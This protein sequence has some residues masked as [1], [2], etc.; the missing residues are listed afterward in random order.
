MIKTRNPNYRWYMLALTMATYGL[1][2]G[3]ARMSMLVL[4]KQI[5]D[6]LDLSMVAIGTIWGMDPLAGVFIGLPSGLLADRFGV[7]RTVVVVCILAGVFGALRG[8]TVDFI[9]MAGSMFLFGLTVASLPSIAPKVTMVW[10]GGRRL[11]LANAMLNVA[12]SV[13]AMT[14]TMFSATVFSPWLGGWRGVM[15]LYGA[16]AVLMGFLWLF[17]GREPDRGEVPEATEV[18]VPFRQ[19]LSKVVRIRNVW[20]FGVITMTS[21]GANTGFAGYLPLYLRN[22]GWAPAAADGAMT[23]MSG[24]SILG[25]IP[26]VMLAER[27][28]RKGILAMSIIVQALGIGLVSVLDTPGVWLLI[29][30]GGFLRSGA[31]ALYNV[32]IFETEGVGSTYGGTAVGLSSTIAM[33]GAFLAPPLGNSFAGI[34]QGLPMVFWGGMAML[35]LP[36]LFLVKNRPVLDNAP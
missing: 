11:G 10:F 20:L 35:G 30:V 8:F 23:V 36:A 27:T 4:F 33:L 13:G 2:T 5:A 17:T 28:S 19:A 14:A 16:P 21:W 12:W 1:I 32:M 18:K 31:P 15:F 9:T 26:M 3:A 7:K 34:H 25:V 6:D 22:I 24:I 29:V